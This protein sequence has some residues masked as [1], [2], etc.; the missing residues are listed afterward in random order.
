MVLLEEGD[1]LRYRV[2][3]SLVGTG[4]DP[5]QKV[6]RPERMEGEGEA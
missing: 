3:K 2:L 5:S 1:L 4:G 6:L